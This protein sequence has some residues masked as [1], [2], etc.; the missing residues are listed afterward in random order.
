MAALA[1][2]YLRPI[3]FLRNVSNFIDFRCLFI[4]IFDTRH[5]F[6]FHGIGTSQ[7]KEILEL[8]GISKQ[9]FASGEWCC[10]S[11]FLR[12]RWNTRIESQKSRQFQYVDLLN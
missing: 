6:Y 3:H 5:S 1:T 7:P 8:A 10:H 9:S 11:G 4:N 12:S 2:K